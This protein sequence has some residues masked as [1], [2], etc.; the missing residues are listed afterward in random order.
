VNRS[1][2]V[3]CKEAVMRWLLLLLLVL[4]PT[5]QA[6]PD[7]PELSP[8]FGADGKQLVGD[9]E[10]L[11]RQLEARTQEGGTLRV[12]GTLSLDL[13]V[14][15]SVKLSLE[16]GEGNRLRATVVKE[17]AD[18]WRQRSQWR[19]QL[20]AVSD[21][22]KLRVTTSVSGGEKRVIEKPVRMELG[23]MLRRAIARCGV[24]GAMRFLEMESRE[25]NLPHG[26]VDQW[27]QVSEFKALGDAKVGGIAA[28]VIQYRVGVAGASQ[29]LW[30]TLWVDAKTL[31]PLKRVCVRE[32]SKLRFVERLGECHPGVA[33]DP[34][35]FALP[36]K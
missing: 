25:E 33:T 21:G 32:G 4:V 31:L 1:G 26:D 14:D 2:A 12:S 28:R 34:K 27:L 6:R 11:L 20:D 7:A 13:D 24:Y 18:H 9:G 10:L 22:N 8:K 29:P 19:R 5:R 3:L 30:L 35:A 36:G 16:L 15:Y 23:E 17:M